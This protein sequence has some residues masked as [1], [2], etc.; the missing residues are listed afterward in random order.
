[1]AKKRKSERAEYG[2]GSIYRNKDGSYTV[3]VRLK[4]GAKP[5]RKRAADLATAEVVKANLLKLRDQGIVNSAAELDTAIA[6]LERL[7]DDYIDVEQSLQSFETFINRWYNE[8][9]KRRKNITERTLDH[10]R[11]MI[12][13][14]LLPTFGQMTLIQIKAPHV[15]DFVNRLSDHLGDSTVKQAFGVLNQALNTAAAWKFI[16]FNPCAGVEKPK[17]KKQQ[18]PAL[19][20]AHVQALFNVIEGHPTATTFHVMATL[21]TRLGETLALRRIDFNA[22]FSEVKIATQISY[23]THERVTPKD[24]SV[25]P[26]P[27]PPRLQARLQAQWAVVCAQLQDAGPDFQNQGLLFPSEAGTPFQSSNVEKVW[28]GF[29]KRATTK[30]GPKEYIYPG[31]KAKA[32]LPDWATIHSL[33]AFVA[34]TLEDVGAEQRTTGHVL[35]HGAKNVTEKYIRRQMSTMRRALEKVEAVLW[36]DAENVTRHSEML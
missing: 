1:M 18:K 4:A 24:D 30:S 32:E 36:A 17:A 3:A 2:D 7:R 10:Y 11:G 5:T 34:T 13:R 31:F 26:L 19:T 8:V 33:R 15:N 35:G 29:T 23:H 16:P 6:T 21:G 12:R 9:V 20:V 14:Y 25:R 27:V 28:H 22:D